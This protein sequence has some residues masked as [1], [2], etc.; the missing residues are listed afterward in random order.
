MLDNNTIDIHSHT[1]SKNILYSLGYLMEEA[2]RSGHIELYEI[3]RTAY[4]LGGKTTNDIE[5]M[6]ANNDST[7]KAAQFIFDFLSA[8]TDVQKETLSILEKNEGQ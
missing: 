6:E 5:I 3:M 4:L 1:N 7:L 8:S 2:K